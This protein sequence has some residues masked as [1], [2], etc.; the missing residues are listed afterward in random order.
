M[1]HIEGQ[2]AQSV[3]AET[4]MIAVFFAGKWAGRTVGVRP[5]CTVSLWWRLKILLSFCRQIAKIAVFLLG[6]CKDCCLLAG[7]LQQLLS[8]LQEDYKDCCLFAGKL[9]R[10]FSFC[11]VMAKIAVFLQGDCWGFFARRLQRLLS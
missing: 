8:F 9:Q 10:L 7:R 11:K 1:K 5:N 6:D 4:A 2:I 3:P